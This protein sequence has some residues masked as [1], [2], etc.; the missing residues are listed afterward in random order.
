MA[1]KHQSQGSKLYIATELSPT[2]W[3]EV[4]GIKSFDGPGGQATVIDAS[5]LSSTFREKLMGLADEGQITFGGNYISSDPGQAE[6]LEARENRERRQFRMDIP[7][8][9]V[10]P[11]TNPAES[12]YFFGFVLGF[13]IAGG[14]DNLI[15]ANITVE[16]DGAVVRV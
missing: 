12:W 1:D 7:A 13:N 15:E 8:A 16:V 9:A 14:V 5:D 6:C 4:K 11:A 3:V 10:S 2:S